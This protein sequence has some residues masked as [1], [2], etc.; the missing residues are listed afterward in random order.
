MTGTDHALGID[1]RGVIRACPQCGQR[2]RLAFSRLNESF[3]CGKCQTELRPPDEPV[4]ADS[5]AVFNAITQQ[6]SV[7]VLVDFWAAWCG[8]CKMVAPELVKVARNGAGRWVIVK[9]DTEVLPGIAARYRISAIPTLVL[10]Q[11]GTEVAR[12]S[13]AL[14]AR[15][16]EQFIAPAVT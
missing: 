9:V 13:G 5:E 10:F 14:P 3:R 11:R 16:I 15:A 12:Q 8:P 7:P 4:E 6:S 2:N 1:D